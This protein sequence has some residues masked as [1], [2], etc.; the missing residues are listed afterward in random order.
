MS[1]SKIYA[2]RLKGI[3]K[4]YHL[5]E[6]GSWC[7]DSKVPWD[8]PALTA[9]HLPVSLITYFKHV[10]LQVNLATRPQKDEN[11]TLFDAWQNFSSVT[12]RWFAI[13]H[14]VHLRIGRACCTWFLPSWQ[15]ARYIYSIRRE[16]GMHI[17]YSCET[18]LWS[19]A[20]WHSMLIPKYFIPASA[21]YLVRGVVDVVPEFPGLE[22]SRSLHSFKAHAPTMHATDRCKSRLKNFYAQV[23]VRSPWAEP[24][25]ETHTQVIQQRKRICLKEWTCLEIDLD[26]SILQV[27]GRW[28]M[29]SCA[30]SSFWKTNRICSCLST[31]CT[32]SHEKRQKSKC[33]S[34]N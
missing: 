9:S 14:T 16:T 15:N 13:K 3:N 31:S 28:A 1:V 25:W 19:L 29:K 11:T 24:S 33:K 17:S 10:Q 2:I 32:T 8:K 6:S 23:R 12:S 21:R 22:N 26:V 7:F 4:K 5:E 34:W 20:V 30:Q 18:V 27:S